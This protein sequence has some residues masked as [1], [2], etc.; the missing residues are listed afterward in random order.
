MTS[1]V[2]FQIIYSFMFTVKPED[3]ED[4]SH[5][6][7]VDLEDAGS[8]VGAADISSKLYSVLWTIVL[9]NFIHLIGLL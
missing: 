8:L 2:L 1:D 4:P 6:E 9:C 5:N 3:E 7:T